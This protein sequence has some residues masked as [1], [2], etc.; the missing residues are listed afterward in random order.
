MRSHVIHADFALR[1]QALRNSRITRKDYIEWFSKHR[2]LCQSKNY[3]DVNSV[4]L[5]SKLAIVIFEIS[6]DN[7]LIY[8]S[9]IEKYAE[10]GI[11]ISRRECLSHAQKRIR[12][13]L[14]DKQKNYIAAMKPE[15]NTLLLKCKSKSEEKKITGINRYKTQ[16]DLK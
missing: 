13:H 1:Q 3:G 11:E 12:Q 9:V 8:S 4:A 5:E 14:F 10:Y 15:M 16:R 6:I 7:K 2:D